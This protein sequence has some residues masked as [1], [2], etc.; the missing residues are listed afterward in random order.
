MRNPRSTSVTRRDGALPVAARS[1][2]RCG[3]LCLW[4]L[5]GVPVAGFGESDGASTLPA[6]GEVQSS[7]E[8]TTATQTPATAAP[9]PAGGFGV[10]VLDTGVALVAPITSEVMLPGSASFVGGNP[11]VDYA[12]QGTHGTAVA[13]IIRTLSPGSRI[14]SLHLRRCRFLL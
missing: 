12:K 11:L 1:G 7:S 9:A 2:R 6:E 4:L 8:S 14:L 5:L 10:A 3:L 13:Q